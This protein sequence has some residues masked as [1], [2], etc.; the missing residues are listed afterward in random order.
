M[1]DAMADE[2]EV[3]TTAAATEKT[4]KADEPE[5]PPMP[6]MKISQILPLVVMMG[7][8]KFDLD[9]MGYRHVAE[10]VF[11]VVQVLCLGGIYMIYQKIEAMEDKG[12]KIHVPEVKSMGQ[13][14]T[15]AV[16]QTPKEYDQAKIKEQ[17]KQAVMSAVILCGVYYKWQY[18]MPVVLQALMTPVQLYESPLF[19]LHI[20][21][22]TD[23]K[24][25]FP[26]PNPFGLPSAPEAPGPAAKKEDSEK[27]KKT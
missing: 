16:D 27:D 17:G 10:A 14:V 21:S 5:M 24:R 1:G 2:D 6:Q 19:Q 11:L 20:M 13:V 15:P 25:P 26:S 3:A 7:L 18:L 9:Q 8:G 4:E 22:S 23:V 12:E